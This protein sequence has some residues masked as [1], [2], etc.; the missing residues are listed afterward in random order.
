MRLGDVVTLGKADQELEAVDSR[1]DGLIGHNFF[2]NANF[3]IA[4]G[5]DYVPYLGIGAV[6]VDYFN[7]WKRNHDPDLIAT[8]NDPAM[9]ARI[10]GTTS[11]A[12]GRKSDVVFGYQALAG[13]DRRLSDAVTLGIKLRWT[14][15]AECSRPRTNTYR[16]GV[17][18]RAW[19]G[20]IG[21]STGWSP[22]I[23]LRS[24]RSA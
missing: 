22:T 1:I 15:L 21:F 4:S 16:C 6:S 7:R 17:T 8:F 19:G 14:V 3:D 12:A 9:K 18:S 24:L 10:A 5:S 20:G 11:I 2:A 23:S 13:V